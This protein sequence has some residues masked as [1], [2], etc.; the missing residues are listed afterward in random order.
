MREGKVEQSLSGEQLFS[1][2]S[3]SHPNSGFSAYVLIMSWTFILWVTFVAR[4]R[5]MEGQWVEKIVIGSLRQKQFLKT[6]MVLCG[7]SIYFAVSDGSWGRD[8]T[9]FAWLWQSF[10]NQWQSTGSALALLFKAT[11][12][13]IT[14]YLQA[15]IGVR[16]RRIDL[17]ALTYDPRCTGLVWSLRLDRK[18]NRDIH[19]FLRIEIILDSTSLAKSQICSSS[20]THHY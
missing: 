6:L 13:L 5:G 9:S 19:A 18:Y 20:R 7:L 1:V 11:E 12:L 17:A 14:H 4:W 16:F 3:Q 2:S 15:W 10:M 8:Q